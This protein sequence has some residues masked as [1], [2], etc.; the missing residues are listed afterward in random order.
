M[1]EH[2]WNHYWSRDPRIK[3]IVC[4]SSSSWILRNIVNNRGGLYNRVTENINLEPFTLSQTKKY[5]IHEN[6]HIPDL[7][8]IHLYM[9]LG[10]IPYYL[11]KVKPGLSAIQ[12]VESLAFKKNCFLLN[13][14]QNLYAT[15]FD[16]SDGHIELA[17]IIAKHRFGIGQE[18]LAH[19]ASHVSSGG[20]LVRKLTELEDA[21]FIQ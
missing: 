21:G 6:I 19:K 10:G 16:V 8:I 1:L 13:E 7:M 15:L 5:L 9:V 3:L 17:R 12:V 14:F 18:D 11:S 20:S 4:G 2:Y